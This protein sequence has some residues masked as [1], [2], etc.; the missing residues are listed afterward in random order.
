[1]S[2]GYQWE[3]VFIENL[4]DIYG[5]YSRMHP[6]DE[7]MDIDG[8]MDYHFATINSYQMR[9]G[10]QYNFEALDYISPYFGAVREHWFDGRADATIRQNVDLETPISNGSGGVFELG[11]RLNPNEKT[12]LSISFGVEGYVGD[13]ECFSGSLNLTYS[14]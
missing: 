10:M 7:K 3:D 2:L 9:L 11:I 1:M 8:G 13:R 5:R 14:F 4:L 6:E 12:P